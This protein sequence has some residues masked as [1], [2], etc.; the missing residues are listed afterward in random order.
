MAKTKINR[1][2]SVIE[3]AWLGLGDLNG[4]EIENPLVHRSKFNLDNPGYLETYLMQQ[5]HF[6]SFAAKTLLDIDLLPIQ[7]V[8]MEELWNHPFPMFLMTRGGSKLLREDELIRTKESWTKIRDIKVGDKVYGSDGKLANVISKTSLQRN[9]NMYRITLRDGRQIE[10]C[11]DHQWKVWSKYKNQRSKDII[12]SVLSTKELAKN[13]F[14]IRKD[15]KASTYKE[16][17]EYHYALPINLPLLDEDEK[18]YL[19][20]PYIVGVLLGDG[21]ITQ[22]TIT[23]SSEDIDII[24][25]VRELL[26]NGYDINLMPST[27]N[28]YIITCSKKNKIAFYKLC[29]KIGIWKH[30][31]HT[32]FIPEEYKYGSYNQRL[33]LLKGLMDTDGT[34]D[35]RHITYCTVSNKLSNDF[36]DVARS[37]GLHCKHS[38][39]ESWFNGNRY[40]DCNSISIYTNKPIFSLNRKLDRYINHTKSKQ[41]QSRY[42]KVFITNIEY[43]GKGNG[44]CI[45]VDNEDSTY[46]TKDYIVT[47]N[48][49]LGAVY[50]ILK[51]VLVPGTKFIGVGAGYRQS[52]ILYE[53]I[54]TIWRNAPVLRS[55]CGNSSGPSQKVD[56]CEVVLNESVAR[57]MP[58]GN[59]EK[60]RGQRAGIIWSDEFSAI[61]PDIYEVVISGFAAV[62][63][64]PVDMVKQYGRRKALQEQGKW[65]NQDELY[66][67]TK[68]SNQSIIS[69][70]ADY[71]FM[72]FADYWRKY[73]VYINSKGDPNKAV[74]LPNGDIKYLRDY[75]EDGIIPESFDHKDYCIIRIP[76]EL[77]PKGFMDEKVIARARG[78]MDRSRFQKE[79]QAIFPT[80]SDGFFK[81]SLLQS[82]VA[83]D[84]NPVVLPSGPVWFDAA[85]RGNMSCKYVY[86]IDPAA[87]ADNFAIVILELHPDHTRIVYSWSTNIADFQRRKKAG[88]VEENDYYGFCSRKI[89]NLMKVFPT[90]D[91]V[92][93]AQG[94]GRA[95]IEAL[96]DPNKLQ[97]GE[98]FLWPTNRVLDPNK[99]LPTD[100][101]AG[102]HIC[103]MF[104][105]A[106][107]QLTSDA[108]HWTRKDFEEKL[109]LFPRFDSV[110]LEVS[111][112]QDNELKEKLKVNKLYDTLEDCVMEIEELKNELSTIVLSRTGTGVGG[113][114]R[115]DTPETVNA[116]G[117]KGRLRKDRY[118]AL[119]MANYVAHS[120]QRAPADVAYNV[121]G[122][123]SHQLTAQKN[124]QK[125][126]GQMYAQGPDWFMKGMNN[127][128]I[129]TAIK[130]MA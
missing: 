101:E 10:C 37:I 19:I 95:I 129:V 76:Y 62:S 25:R 74:K 60:I 75:F 22:K 65:S 48:S 66:F 78:S 20:H 38:I 119:V 18:E 71:D 45:Q 117:K 6:L 79:Y 116:E 40:A 109:L 94:G 98:L 105:F 27:T 80:D 39:R 55:L 64:K 91:I 14:N 34:A 31:S 3:D 82:C 32:K 85:I 84:I 93:D 26:P 24:N 63:Q 128:R 53:Y 11:E 47:H 51:C 36:L 96:H 115:W 42:D 58:I 16:C 88:M 120:I 110:T 70:T 81:R 28:S 54:Q 92:I 21:C 67:H 124:A 126:N 50:T 30:N 29:Q 7:A 127:Q 73:W 12:W 44:Y 41:G 17:K 33:E 89:R 107:A 77:L 100:V 68:S 103:H 15:S 97:A 102:L 122:G 69:G 123:F 121:I 108:N 35:S 118:S 104:Q 125:D 2:N 4:I 111:A 8:I 52:R 114:D 49:F 90:D 57:F 113:R 87:E 106:N 1:L 99:E 83:T 56:M 112:Y 13:Y 61:P 43:I 5:P 86:G 9:V 46:L 72:H 130:K 23:I 59:G